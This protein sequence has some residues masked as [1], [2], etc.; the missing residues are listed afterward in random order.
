MLRYDELVVYALINALCKSACIADVR[1]LDMEAT[2]QQEGEQPKQL[3]ILNCAKCNLESC[4]S[5]TV[6]PTIVC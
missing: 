3:R 6:W 4:Y 2:S 1:E 5:G